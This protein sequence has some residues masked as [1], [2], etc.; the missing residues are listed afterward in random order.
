MA[1]SRM[2]VAELYEAQALFQVALRDDARASINDLKD[3]DA[4]TS[5]EDLGIMAM[6]R[7]HRFSVAAVA[8]AGNA[9]STTPVVSS[10]STASRSSTPTPSTRSKT[11]Q[12]VPQADDPSDSSDE[13]NAS[14]SVLGILSRSTWTGRQNET[15]EI[16]PPT[17]EVDHSRCVR[18][19][20]LDGSRKS[21][22]L[23]QDAENSVVWWGIEK[24]YFFDATTVGKDS[25]EI[26]WYARGDT[27]RRRP[28]FVWWKDDYKCSSLNGGA[29][30]KNWIAAAEKNAVAA[31]AWIPKQVHDSKKAR[32]KKKE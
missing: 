28:R 24:T 22:S 9:A 20:Y 31:K 16:H 12:G 18:S 6:E 15:Y 17:K 4:G 5:S 1:A 21:Y 26:C 32:W 11:S 3:A 13:P 23:V 10:A 25:M 14:D 29:S 7:L 27:Q 2:S 19:S 30:K 8:T